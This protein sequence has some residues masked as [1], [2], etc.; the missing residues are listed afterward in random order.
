VLTGHQL[1]DPDLTV[2]YHSGNPELHAKKLHPAGVHEM[3]YA[4]PPVVVEN[5][6]TAILK[7]IGI[8]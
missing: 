7:A 6:E 2:A 3:P 1:K 4:N 5:D 8:S